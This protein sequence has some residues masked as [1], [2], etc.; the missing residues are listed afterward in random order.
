MYRKAGD[1]LVPELVVFDLKSKTRTAVT[2]P[3]DAH[4]HG[5]CWSPD[6]KRVAYVWEPHAA[7]VE[8]MNRFGPQPEKEK[9]PTFTVTVARP[10]GSDAK[11]V[12]TEAEYGYGSIDWS[13]VPFPGNSPPIAPGGAAK[14]N[15]DKPDDEAAVAANIKA[16]QSANS[17]TRATAAAELQRIVAKY[18]SG[19]IY[20]AKKD[21]GEAV[22][23]EKV[24]RIDAGM[25]KA[26]VF[27]ILPLFP[28][29]PGIS[30]HGSGD[31]HIVSYRL[32]YHWMVTIYYRN[33]DKV[34]ERPTL[35]KRAMR[36]HVAPP[37]DF[38]GTWATW[39]VNGQ[40]GIETQY[41]DGR[42]DG[43]LTSYHDNG[44]KGFEQHYANNEIHG[45][46]SGWFPNGKVSYTAHYRNGKKEGTWTHWYANANK[47]SETSYLNGQYDGRDTNWHENGQI[48]FVNDY[49]NGVRHGREAAWDENGAL[50]YDRKY[51]DGKLVE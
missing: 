6:G 32:D 38:T 47:H 22:W 31:S 10:D 15:V 4:V 30:E 26:E 5:S 21:G 2:V 7:Y 23:R 48:R 11:D 8:R 34:I 16:L 12:Y 49:K 20:L 13:G 43:V 1:D 28:E 44:A 36:V 45:A 35:T 17:E 14:P 25:T 3:K 29:E 37:K 40:K 41:K 18:P 9:T 19:T 46:D 39:H 33:P 50:Q 27:K 42:Y 51:V 24:N